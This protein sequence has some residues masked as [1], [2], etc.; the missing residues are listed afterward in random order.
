MKTITRDVSS[1]AELDRCFEEF[2]RFQGWVYRGQADASWGLIPNLARAPIVQERALL[3]VSSGYT[4][5][6]VAIAFPFNVLD[7]A[8]R[9]RR[10]RSDAA[11]AIERQSLT[12]WERLSYPYLTKRPENDWE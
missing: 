9:L 11:L 8:E 1:F 10:A 5:E 2:H 7:V 6:S 4:G 12:E 3:T